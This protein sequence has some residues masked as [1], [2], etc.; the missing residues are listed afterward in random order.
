MSAQNPLSRRILV[1]GASGFVGQFLLEKLTSNIQAG[2][3]IVALH[4]RRLDAALK[5]RFGDCVAWTKADIAADDLS[6]VVAGVDTA[7]HLAAYSTTSESDDEC[8]HLERVN[9]LGTRRLASACKDGGVKHFILVSSIAACENATLSEI[10]ETNGF[11]VSAYG[12]SKRAAEQLLMEM[13]G[14][15]F[16]ATVLRPTALFGETHLG[17]IYELAKLIAQR[18]FFQFGKGNGQ[19][20]FYY[21]R[22]FVDVLSAVQLDPRTYG[23]TFIAADEPVRLFDLVSLISAELELRCNVLNIPYSLGLCVAITCDVASKIIG[24]PLP[25]STRRFRAMTGNTSY[26]SRKLRE[27]LGIF[28]AF[29]MREGLRRAIAWYRVAELIS[30]R[31]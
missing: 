23:Q 24:R 4:N 13:A 28:P 10:D 18:R 8:R 20:N 3:M 27:V 15:G 7:F 1:T 16:E 12:R 31:P 5:D 19:T 26:S 21:I 22:D 14:N 11:P 6:E 17:S 29:G 9:V 25:L 2:T 30:T